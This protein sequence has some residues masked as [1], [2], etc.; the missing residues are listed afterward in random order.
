M[1]GSDQGPTDEVLGHG[2]KTPEDE[3]SGAD[4]GKRYPDDTEGHRAS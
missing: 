4:R 1:A 3:T 2:Y